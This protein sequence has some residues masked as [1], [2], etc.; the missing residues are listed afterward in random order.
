M[1]NFVLALHNIARWVVII[2]GIVAFGLS[3]SGWLGKRPWTEQVRKFL[4]YFG[5]SADVQLLLGLILY[6]ISP[7][8][9]MGLSNMGSSDIRFFA[10][11]HPITMF[12]GVVFAHLAGIL[13]RRQSEDQGKFKRAALFSLIAVLL[14]LAGIPWERRLLPF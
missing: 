9:L 11:E 1:Y 12:L 4:S 14:I 8:G 7:V 2:V 5:I 6:F 3:L 13:P 10:L